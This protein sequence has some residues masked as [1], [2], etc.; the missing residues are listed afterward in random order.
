M[1]IVRNDLEILASGKGGFSITPSDVN[2]IPK[3]RGIYI[4]GAGHLDVTFANGSRVTLT[5][6][7]VGMTHEWQ[8]IKVWAAG[9]TATGIVGIL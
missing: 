7:A 3:I 8:I 2:D 6:V 4:G 1:S 5:N 9:T